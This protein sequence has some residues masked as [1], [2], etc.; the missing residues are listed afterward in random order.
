[1]KIQQYSP[2]T[3][4]NLP[5]LEK[6]LREAKKAALGYTPDNIMEIVNEGRCAAFIILEKKEVKGIVLYFIAPYPQG[7]CLQ[8]G[9]F[10]Y[11]GNKEWI[12]T[13]LDHMDSEAKRLKCK[14]SSFY[15]RPGLT[16]KYGK[17]F[18]A[19]GYNTH[20]V[21]HWKENK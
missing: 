19:H 11:V 8:A 20:R 7:L 6:L 10:T 2:E 1:M 15:S 13:I 16:K 3:K 17:D 18:K 9:L 5:G 21:L 12:P 14:F 4:E